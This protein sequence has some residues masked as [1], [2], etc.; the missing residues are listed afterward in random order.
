M[1]FIFLK[2]IF[3]HNYMIIK[4]DNYKIKYKVYKKINWN[5]LGRQIEN[6][7]NIKR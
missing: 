2:N 7:A 4:V 3:L 6:Q 5:N 1:N